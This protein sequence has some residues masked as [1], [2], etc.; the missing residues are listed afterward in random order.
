[1]TAV[2]QALAFTLRAVKT[3]PHNENWRKWAEDRLKT[4]VISEVISR[5]P[6]PATDVNVSPAYRS[7]ESVKLFS[8][9]TVITRSKARLTCNSTSISPAP[10]EDDDSPDSPSPSPRPRQ[11]NVMVVLPA[12]P[13]RASSYK[14][15]VCRDGTR[16]YCTQKCLLGLVTRGPLDKTCPNFKEHGRNKH[17]IDQPRLIALLEAQF[18]QKP[19]PEIELGC[20]SLYRH[21]ARGGL[22]E[23]TIFSHGYTFVAKGFPWKYQ[24]YLKHEKAVYDRLQPIQGV[25]VPVCLGTIDVSESPMHFD[26]HTLV[27]HLLLLSHAGTNIGHCGVPKDRVI[28]AATDSMRAVHEQGVLHCD[29]ELRNMLWNGERILI[30]D[31]D[32]AVILCASRVPLG[33]TSH[34]QTRKRKKRSSDER[35]EKR[36]ELEQP[37]FE[38]EFSSMLGTWSIA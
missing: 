36:V 18:Q 11:S 15:P 8:R 26:G 7:R 10:D 38:L 29:L 31:F 4:W 21:G 9:M 16:R 23:V 30:I 37:R 2:A 3:A 1:M 35:I 12:P 28:S 32:R 27:S 13:A 34:N 22:F 19:D 33:N 25:H 24:R 14:G 6:N 17:K 20:E 5:S